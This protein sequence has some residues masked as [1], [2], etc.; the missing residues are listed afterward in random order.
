MEAK[1]PFPISFS[2]DAYSLCLLWELTKAFKK[3]LN[4][5]IKLSF[6]Y[7]KGFFSLKLLFNDFLISIKNYKPFL[8]KFI[9]ELLQNFELMT[10]FEYDT[11]QF[12]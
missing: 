12:L 5:M 6:L 11:R 10:Y 3:S 7:R 1:I 8:L 9:K 2:I 4:L